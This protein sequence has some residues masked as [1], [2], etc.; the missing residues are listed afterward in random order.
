MTHNKTTAPADEDEINLTEFF[1]TLKSY[2]YSIIFI[3]ILTTFLA[4]VFAYLSPNIYQ[5]KTTITVKS[6]RGAGEDFMSMA[7][8]QNNANLDNEIEILKSR[9]IISKALENLSI[10]TRYYSTKHYKTKELYRSSPFVVKAE[11]IGDRV[12]TPFQLIPVDDKHFQLILEPSQKSK[13]ITLLRSLPEDKTALSYNET[14]RYGETIVTPWFNINVQKVYELTDPHYSFTVT[15]NE[16]MYKFILFKLSVSTVAKSTIIQLSFSDAIAT[17]ATEIV[18]AIAEAYIQETIDLKTES[19]EKTLHFIDTQ[20]EA[21]N[22]TLQASA[23]TLQEYKATNIV[24][25]IENKA[26]ITASKLAELESQRYELDMQLG[27]LQNTLTYIQTHKDIS[28]IDLGITQREASSTINLL[29]QKIQEA[30]SLRNSL[31]V[32]FT[33]LHPDVQKVTQ[34][35]IS[36]RN[37]L[38]KTIQSSIRSTKDRKYR[39]TKIINTHTQQMESL[40]KQQR[41]LSRLTRNFMV[42]EKIY[43][44]LLEKRAETAIVQSSTVSE[45]RIIDKALEPKTPI[46]PNRMFIIIIGFIL[47]MTLGVVLS[48]L[49]NF[50]D[51]T[52]KTIEDIE[53]ITSIPIYGAVPF[54][55]SSKNIQPFHEALRVVRTNLEFLSSSQ[56]SKIITITSS[57]PTEGKTTISTELANIIA[58]SHKKVLLI[59]LDMRRARIHEKYKL[60]NNIGISTLLSGKNTLEEVIQTTQVENLNIISAGPVPLNPSEL[61]LTDAFKV[62]I[63]SLLKQYDYILFDSPPVGLVTDAMILMKLSDINLFVFKANYSKKDF[64]KNINRIVQEKELSNTGI[65]LNGVEMDKNS[66]YG[67]GYGYS[68]DYAHDYYNSDK[69]T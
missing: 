14:H 5:A 16:N 54:I 55:S 67:Y 17:R 38:V 15:P 18:N 19:G 44:F 39:L 59:D 2:K 41:D 6:E 23:T 45:A 8:G 61:L 69:K 62:T 51:N 58:R 11:F 12:L 49:R 1:T 10:G 65:I 28:G 52:I 35:L 53:S 46:K 68:Y 40:P 63:D 25:D 24:V 48:L 50:R 47:G 21:I 33:E 29:I 4:S 43:S 27:V 22:K 34:Q 30:S 3:T 26:Q 32:D 64:I 9:L 13:F 36:L 37:S 66:G 57:I 7:L 56:K 20:L 31:L 60:T 42:N